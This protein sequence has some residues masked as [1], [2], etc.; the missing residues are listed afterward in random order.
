MAERD[1]R[2]QQ[3]ATTTAVCEPQAHYYR[4][5]YR[6]NQGQPNPLPQLP[7]KGRWLEALGFSTG[8]AIVVTARKGRLIIEP[9]LKG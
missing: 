5:G 8:Q 6:P 2:S 3:H 1:S 7:L 4:V 9:Q